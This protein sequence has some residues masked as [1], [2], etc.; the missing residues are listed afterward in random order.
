M[1]LLT[2]LYMRTYIYI[3][4]YAWCDD[5]ECTFKLFWKKKLSCVCFYLFT[6]LNL[7]LPLSLLR[8]LRNKHM[9]THKHICTFVFK[10]APKQPLSGLQRPMLSSFLVKCYMRSAVVVCI[11][12]AT[13]S[14]TFVFDSLCQSRKFSCDIH[15]WHYEIA[16]RGRPEIPCLS[17]TP[18][19]IFYIISFREFRWR[20]SKKKFVLLRYIFPIYSLLTYLLVFFVVKPTNTYTL[21]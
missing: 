6:F 7:V 17:N 14:R 12:L 1:V 19:I 9:L 20:N 10:Y 8:F 18:S 4:T 21:V 5:D 15:T 3:C 11:Y 16:K 2:K 13:I